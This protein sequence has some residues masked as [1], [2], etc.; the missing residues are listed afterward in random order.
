MGGHMEVTT[1][2]LINDSTPMEFLTCQGGGTELSFDWPPHPL[3]IDATE[4]GLRNLAKLV[5]AAV[6]DREQTKA[7]G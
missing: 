5:N 6:R 3:V 1:S 4:Q 7:R 2:V